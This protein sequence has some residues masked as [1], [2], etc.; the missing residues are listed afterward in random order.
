MDNNQFFLKCGIVHSPELH[1]A[2]QQEDRVM[3]GGKHYPIMLRISR[4]TTITLPGKYLLSNFN[5]SFDMLHIM[6]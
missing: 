6:G 4:K 1:R 5:F 3:T 2:G